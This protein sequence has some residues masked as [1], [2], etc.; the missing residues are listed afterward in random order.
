MKRKRDRSQREKN[1]FLYKCFSIQLRLTFIHSFN[2]KAML[3]GLTFIDP[4]NERAKAVGRENVPKF[5]AIFLVLYIFF[6][7]LYIFLID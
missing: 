7:Y 5:L 3:V 1:V 4:F 2:E 6:S